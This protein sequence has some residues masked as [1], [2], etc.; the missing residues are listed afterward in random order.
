M[1]VAVNKSSAG[2]DYKIT[3]TNV[4][5]SFLGAIRCV[6]IDVGFTF[7]VNSIYRNIEQLYYGGVL[8]FGLKQYCYKSYFLF[9]GGNMHF[10]YFTISVKE[11]SKE[12]LNF[13]TNQK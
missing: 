7:D 11:E 6:L 12:R 4:D 2:S 10:S 1:N 5:V 13:K 9:C 3:I 8:L